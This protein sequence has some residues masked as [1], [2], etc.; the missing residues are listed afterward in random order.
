MRPRELRMVRTESLH[1]G[2]RTLESLEVGG[3]PLL[4]PLLQRL[5]LE[6]FLEEALGQPHRPLKV[7]HADMALLLVRNIALSRHPLDQVPQ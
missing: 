5:R 6:E 7:P 1:G 2:P 4:E 3:H